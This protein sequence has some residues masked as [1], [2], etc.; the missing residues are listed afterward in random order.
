MNNVTRN[1]TSV[2]ADTTSVNADTTSDNDNVL[3]D[4]A[5]TTGDDDNVFYNFNNFKRCPLWHS[6]KNLPLIKI[7]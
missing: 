7:F 6:L 3:G 5:D 2:T 4:N 1:S